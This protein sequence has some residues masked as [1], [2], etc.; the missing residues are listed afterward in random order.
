M[1]NIWT[2]VSPR[3]C[4]AG[5][6]RGKVGPRGT[7]NGQYTRRAYVCCRRSWGGTETGGYEIITHCWKLLLYCLSLE[8]PYHMPLLLVK[9]TFKVFKKWYLLQHFCVILDA[10]KYSHVFNIGSHLERAVLHCRS[11]EVK[12]SHYLLLTL[13]LHDINTCMYASSDYSIALCYSNSRITR[14]HCFLEGGYSTFAISA[15]IT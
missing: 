6:G 10:R 8:F 14:N 13:M 9:M 2:Y 1:W 5:A 11:P 12:L 15:N 7:G 4:I 3:T